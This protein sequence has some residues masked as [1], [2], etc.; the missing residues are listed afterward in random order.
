MNTHPDDMLAEC[1]EALVNSLYRK[2]ER[3]NRCQ[4][5]MGGEKQERWVAQGRQ[6]TLSHVAHCL[7]MIHREHHDTSS[8]YQALQ[9]YM[10]CLHKSEADAVEEAWGY[11]FR[12][13]TAIERWK[14]AGEAKVLPRVSRSLYRLLNRCASLLHEGSRQKA[15]LP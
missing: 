2:A 7:K 14:A 11:R 10:H 12:N 15:D 8:L 1:V 3:I 4:R 13:R 6:K 5:V 9:D